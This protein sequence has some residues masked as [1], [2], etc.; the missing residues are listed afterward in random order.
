MS[1]FPKRVISS[2]RWAA[3]GLAIDLLL[4]CAVGV[5][6][7]PSSVVKV[8]EAGAQIGAMHILPLGTLTVYVFIFLP[9]I[10]AIVYFFFAP[11][12]IKWRDIPVEAAIMALAAF[13]PILAVFGTFDYFLQVFLYSIWFYILSFL[14][15]ALIAK[16]P[17]FLKEKSFYTFVLATMFITAVSTFIFFGMILYLYSLNF[18]WGYPYY[19]MGDYLIIAIVGLLIR[20]VWYRIMNKSDDSC[21]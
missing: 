9:L 17:A 3:M 15:Y 5:I 16:V 18:S 4:L 2:N 8:P 13:M 6:A 19:L 1:S 21:L 14:T 12:R 11:R 7:A 10:R 20:F